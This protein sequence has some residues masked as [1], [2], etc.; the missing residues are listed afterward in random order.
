MAKDRIVNEN[1]LSEEGK[2]I[3]SLPVA[4][5]CH[6]CTMYKMEDNPEH[7]ACPI[8]KLQ[9]SENATHCAYCG[10]EF[11]LDNVTA[12]QVGEHIDKCP[13]HPIAA[14]KKQI[15]E[16]E[17][18][19]EADTLTIGVLA[20]VVDVLWEDDSRCEKHGYGNVVAKAK[21]VVARAHGNKITPAQNG[22]EM[23]S[24]ERLRQ[25]HEEGRS[26]EHDTGHRLGEL[27]IAAAELAVDSTDAWVVNPH[28]GDDWGLVAKHGYNG[29]KSNRIR[30]LTMSGALVAAE[31]DRLLPGGKAS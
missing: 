4:C 8:V 23:I 18:Q 21:D 22:V 31:I 3:M 25:I 20:D 14:L 11:P 9:A 17:Y 28:G 19:H 29:T 2:L 15:A 13:K 6:E 7:G 26:A 30:A 10:E 27:A 1:P 5:R 12:D 16:L 24:D